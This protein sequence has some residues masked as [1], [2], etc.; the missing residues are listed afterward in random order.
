[1]LEILAPARRRHARAW[2]V[3]T[4]GIYNS[5]YFEHSFLAQ[6]M[7]V[8]LVEGR[9]LVVSGGDVF[10]RT[11]KGLERVD[12]IYRRVDDDFLD[13]EAFRADSLLG[14]PGLMAAYRAGRVA[15]ANAPGNGVADDKVIYAYVPDM[16]RYYEGE[17]PILPNVPTYLCWRDADRKYVLENLDEAGGQGRQRNRRLRHAGGP[18][19]HRRAARG[20]RRPHPG[21]PAQLHRPAH[22]RALPRAHHRRRSFRRPPRRSAPL[23]AL[24]QGYLRAARRPDPRRHAQGLAGG[25]LL[26]GRRQQGHLG[27]RSARD[28]SQRRSTAIAMPHTKPLLSRVADAVYWM[29]RYIERAENVARF[30]DVNH[31]LM[32]DLPAGLRRPVAA[33]RGHHRRPRALPG[34]LRRRHAGERGALPGLR[35]REPQLD[36][37]L[38]AGRARKCAQRP[39]NHLLGNVGADQ[40]PL[41][42]DHRRKPQARAR[43]PARRSAT[44][45]AWP[46]TCSTASLHVTMSHNEAW[47]FIRL[48]AMLER[49][50]KTTRMLDVKY[51]ILLPSVSDVGTPYDD[52]QWSAVLKS[53]SGFEMYRKRYGR[54]SPDR[55]VEF[56]LLDG[57]FPRAFRYCIGLADRALHAITGTPVG[58]FSCPSEQRMGVLAQRTGFRRRGSHPRRRPARILRRGAD[59]NE[60]NR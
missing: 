23:R 18:A 16:I 45:S 47:Q 58:A 3:L 34:T 33:H 54:I 40:Q 32:L 48:G 22:P 1:M 11:T 36:L 50:D 12:V 5:A 25:E 41:P 56:L 19:F 7:G 14:V 8:Q 60:Y 49:A 4:P 39:R 28:R 55:I 35:S 29:G 46:A 21:Q 26:A 37:L 59:E 27:A 10:M 52:V 2:C 6:Q 42:A 9:D 31:N 20:I 53:V 24:R 17:E 44:R 57:E 51:F 30:L 13:P 43:R 38:R 15:L